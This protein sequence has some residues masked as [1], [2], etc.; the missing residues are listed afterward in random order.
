MKIPLVNTTY[1]IR[2]EETDGH[3]PMKFE[4]NDGDIY[5]CKYRISVKKEELDCLAY[6]I[7]ANRL[8]VALDIKTPDIALVQ[9]SSDSCVKKDLK[10]NQRAWP[11]AIC[12]GSK[13][14]KASS[15]VNGT[16][17]FAS[18]KEVNRY[19][20]H[21]D[22]IKIAAFDLMV[23]NCDRGRADN[24]NLLESESVI[25]GKRQ[26][27]FYAIDHAF[28]FGGIDG[29]RFFKPDDNIHY[30]SKLIDSEYFNSYIKFV[31]KKLRLKVLEEFVNSYN[32]VYLKAIQ[33]AFTLFHCSWEIPEN[34]NE[35]V[36]KFL[37]NPNRLSR[38]SNKMYESLKLL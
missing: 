30:G 19:T 35:R 21:T 16:Q 22:L 32:E 29:L 4:C 13:L 5:Y 1:F 11:N 24:I 10:H 27:T 15:L 36:V 9:L 12:F 26:L 31:P 2:E 20:N 34:L 17:L 23:D 38:I 37:S 8:L 3:H 25:D 14:I 7:I 28:I 18:K 6:E 33:S